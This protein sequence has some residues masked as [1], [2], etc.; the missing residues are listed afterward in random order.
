MIQQN[1]AQPESAAAQSKKEVAKPKKEKKPLDPKALRTV[2]AVLGV[3]LLAVS[4]VSAYLLVEK[5][6]STKVTS[7]AS[8]EADG[9]DTDTEEMD[10]DLAAEEIEED[11]ECEECT[12][13]T[14]LPSYMLDLG[15]SGGI[16]IPEGWY[17]S[18]FVSDYEINPDALIDV[19][20]VPYNGGWYQIHEA[21]L[22]EITNNASTITMSSSHTMMLGAFGAEMGPME[23]GYVVFLEPGVGDPDRAGGARKLDGTEY[24]YELIYT[25]D[26]P[27]MCGDYGV[28]SGEIP[29]DRFFF[30]G[31]A[32]D[33]STADDLFEEAFVDGGFDATES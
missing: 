13:G 7:D 31:A 19:L 24:T 5:S 1:D 6:D 21:T 3:L 30:E 8:D 26:D 20:P 28:V 17:V 4:S 23:A 9:E 10:E 22:I 14:E 29:Y 27:V 18:R 12:V 32:E 11:C 15:D 25:C 2:I 16:T 33:L